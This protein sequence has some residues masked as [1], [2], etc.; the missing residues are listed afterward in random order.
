MTRLQKI[1]SVALVLIGFV[2]CFA[3]FDRWENRAAD[4]ATLTGIF[5]TV[6]LLIIG[7]WIL[8]LAGW[9]SVSNP[10]PHEMILIGSVCILGAA[11]VVNS[12]WGAPIS[13]AL[14]VSASMFSR[15]KQG[16][17]G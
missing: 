11:S 2:M 17:A 15:A 13:L 12:T 7:G 16:P 1:F 4:P 9:R 3:F 8:F 10:S 14:L 6:F 5:T